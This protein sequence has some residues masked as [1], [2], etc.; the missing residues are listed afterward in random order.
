MYVLVF[1]I[2]NY[3]YEIL[4]VPATWYMILHILYL[5]ISSSS[6]RE[7]PRFYTAIVWF[8][9]NLVWLISLRIIITEWNDFCWIYACFL[10]KTNLFFKL[11]NI[12]YIWILS[13]ILLC[14]IILWETWWLHGSFVNLVFFVFTDDED[15]IDTSDLISGLQRE[16]DLMDL[17]IKRERLQSLV[18]SD[19]ITKSKF[20]TVGKAHHLSCQFITYSLQYWLFFQIWCKEDRLLITRVFSVL[21]LLI[22]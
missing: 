5:V 1:N 3:W 11:H 9:T 10:L 20:T 12:L 6:M 17:A 22:F 16:V 21:I 7:I 19:P 18:D 4:L 8:L 14:E 2:Q 15:D 13:D